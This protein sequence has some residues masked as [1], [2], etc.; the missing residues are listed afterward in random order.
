MMG[1][2]RCIPG[3]LLR[4]AAVG[5]GSNLAAY[6]FYLGLTA[7]GV[8]PK[9]AMTS[10]YAAS[11]TL[12][13]FGNRNLTFGYSGGL[14]GSG[15]RFV[16]AQSCGYMINLL[17]LSLLVDRFGWPHQ[18]VQ[19]LAILVVAAFLFVTMKAFVFRSKANCRS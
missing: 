1:S 12:G 17:L 2:L 6:A 14:V 5:V 19:G 9:T 4:Y 18:A 15:L 16:V 11:A 10:V 8:G 13:Y 7:A 3:E